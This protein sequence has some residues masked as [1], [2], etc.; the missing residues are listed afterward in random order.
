MLNVHQ[1]DADCVCLLFDAEQ[2]VYSGF[3]RVDVQQP[4]HNNQLKDTKML[5]KT[6]GAWRVGDDYFWLCIYRQHLSDSK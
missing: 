2:E 6:K 1:L 5:L 4:N 3:I